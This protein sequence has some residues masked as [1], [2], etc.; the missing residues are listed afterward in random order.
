MLSVPIKLMIAVILHPILRYLRPSGD[1]IEI[2]G[3]RGPLTRF[4]QPNNL[5][6]WYYSI[7][8]IKSDS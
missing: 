3:G 2:W 1:E 5:G 6:S 7:L 8:H 4:A